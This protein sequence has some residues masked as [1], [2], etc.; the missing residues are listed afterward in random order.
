ME[1]AARPQQYTPLLEHIRS[2]EDLLSG[3]SKQG[4]PNSWLFDFEIGRIPANA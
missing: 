2:R 1:S 3:R 4:G